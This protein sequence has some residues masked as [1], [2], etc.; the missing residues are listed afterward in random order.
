[1]KEKEQKLT[2]FTNSDWV[3]S[4]RDMNSTLGYFFTLGLSVFSWSRRK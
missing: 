1:M 4:V 2:G 3:S